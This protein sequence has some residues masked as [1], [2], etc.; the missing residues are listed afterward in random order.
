M[1]KDGRKQIEV[2]LSLGEEYGSQFRMKRRN[3]L[4]F[5]LCTG[6]IISES[7]ESTTSSSRIIRDIH[8]EKSVRV[9]RHL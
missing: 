6:V 1:E 9:T 7:I 5:F 4:I 3:L 2:S 8:K